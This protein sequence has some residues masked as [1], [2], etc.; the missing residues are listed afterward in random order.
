MAKHGERED[1]LLDA[2]AD[3][4]VAH[5][6]AECTFRSLA[7]A[8][9]T[10]TYTFVYHFGSKAQLI[11]AALRHVSS[12]EVD[13]VRSWMAAGESDAGGVGADRAQVGG[14]GG[15]GAIMRRYWS[16]CLRPPHMQVM[17]LFFEVGSLAQRQPELYPP[18]VRDILLEG[19]ELEREIVRATGADPATVDAM[20][21]LVSGAIWGLQHDLLM[22]GEA[23]R[24]TRALDALATM[25]D[26]HLA[27]GD[28]FAEAV[29]SDHT[30]PSPRKEHV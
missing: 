4:L 7:Q 18:V 24:T 5:G 12:R 8:L 22:T 25:I 17:R 2:V 19:L 30:D 13:E 20:A 3:Y 29:S 1:A 11:D 27:I 16:W 28:P 10:S 14:T 23:D 21:T 15:V 9:D 26:H 6:I